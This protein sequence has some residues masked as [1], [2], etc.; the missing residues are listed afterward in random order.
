MRAWSIKGLLQFWITLACL[1]CAGYAIAGIEVDIRSGRNITASSNRV[2]Y[3]AAIADCS[4]VASIS[5]AAGSFQNEF[6]VEETT[7]NYSTS[8]GCQVG[9]EADGPGLL[10][11]QVTLTFR[12]G[13]TQTHA[14]TFQ[15]DTVQPSISLNNVALSLAD[16][17][18][19][20]VVT[21]DVEEDTDLSYLSFS[22]TG[23]RASDLRAAG[24]VVDKAKESAFASSGE[25]KRVYP[26]R[27]SQ[28]SFT[29]SLPVTEHLTPAEISH[30]GVVLLD[31]AAVD[32]SGNQGSFST[33]AF[34]GA[35]V[36]EEASAL[37][38]SP[39]KIIFTNLLETAAVVPTVDFQFRGPTALPGLGTDITYSSSRPDLV[40]VTP[41]GIVYPLKE[42]NGEP[43]SITV[44][45]PGLGPVDI[46]V[47]TDPSKMLVSLEMQSLDQYG[48]FVID[49]LNGWADLPKVIAVFDDGSKTEISQQFGLRYSLGPGTTGL[50]EM[51]EKGRLLARAVIPEMSPLLLTVQLENQLAVK[52]NI[53]VRAIDALPELKFAPPSRVE[54]GTELVLKAEVSDDVAVKE[55]R[56]LMDGAPIGIRLTEPYEVSLPLGEDFSNRSLSFTAVV[57]DS[58]GQTTMS[59]EKTVKITPKR[60]IT[61]PGLEWESPRELQRVVGGSLM[62]LQLARA[63]NPIEGYDHISYVDFYLDGSLV[64]TSRYPRIEERKIPKPTGGEEK[65]YF[66]IWRLD[67]TVESPSTDE[68]SRAVYGVI[69]VNRDH[70]KQ[71]PSRLV[72]LI[73]NQPPAVRM[74]EPVVGASIS[75][76]QTLKVVAEVSDDTLAQG[77]R[78]ELWLN[79]RLF[80]S[81]FYTDDENKFYDANDVQSANHSFKLPI[82][83]ELIGT[84]LRLQFR[85][86]DKGEEIAQTTIV[87]VPVK[88]D[89]PPTVSLSHPVSGA[90]VVSGLPLELRA[91]AADDVAIKR[92]N[93][94]GSTR[95]RV[96]KIRVGGSVTH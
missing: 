88:G 73:K 53:P 57:I 17:Q 61:I 29:L 34:T 16:G 90:H 68:T 85:V 12:D 84:A 74:I 67:Y 19:Y 65:V 11:P 81:Y 60:K 87:R 37:T 14:E 30:D 24:G 18:Q 20:L 47:E 95:K 89:Q 94:F 63:I 76:G 50:L 66:E 51:D 3:I 28:Q 31:V 86:I 78:I 21:V 1:G 43:V 32:A 22:A 8:L 40:A 45:Y 15:V 79:D 54:V 44:T 80:D 75:V 5:A 46:P 72:R 25:A 71:V 64:G 35:D 62:R 69:H 27:E 91:D 7:R 41:G 70:S 52:A 59:E 56:F 33:I 42:T 48:Q 49:H 9:F 82:S 13:V 58:A 36:V 2:S 92:V 39:A 77:T 38:A 55:V 6:S 10:Q 96:G 83:E 26:E 23:I 4:G 93:F